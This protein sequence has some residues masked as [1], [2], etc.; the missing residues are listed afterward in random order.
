MD[1]S[2]RRLNM[3]LDQVQFLITTCISPHEVFDGLGF[4]SGSYTKLQLLIFLVILYPN[5]NK[6][7]H[8][9]A[10]KANLQL[11]CQLQALAYY[12]EL[13]RCGDVYI[14]HFSSAHLTVPAGDF[15]SCSPSAFGEICL[16]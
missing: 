16:V 8:Y 1:A 9:L 11:C 5:T 4:F 13:F 7:Q 10:W 6:T 3:S 14:W 2:V 15:G 12:E